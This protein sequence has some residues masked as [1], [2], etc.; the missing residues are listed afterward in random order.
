MLDQQIKRYEKRMALEMKLASQAPSSE[1]A[2]AHQRCALLYQSELAIIRRKRTRDVAET[3][4][5]IW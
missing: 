3:L 5:G 1:S 4:S 2:L